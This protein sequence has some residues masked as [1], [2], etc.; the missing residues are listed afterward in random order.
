L[1]EQWNMVFS[2][3]SQ[4]TSPVNGVAALSGSVG[5]AVDTIE[6]PVLSCLAMLA[7]TGLS[8]SPQQSQPPPHIDII[9]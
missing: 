4:V 9:A 6:S 3:E 5:G 7:S 8:T 2:G 1:S